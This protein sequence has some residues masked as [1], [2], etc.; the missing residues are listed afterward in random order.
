MDANALA[1]A[2]GT[3]SRLLIHARVDEA[4]SNWTMPALLR[5]MLARVRGVSNTEPAPSILEIRD[6][7]GHRLL[8]LSHA[9]ALIDVVLP[10]GTYHV[11]AQT[12][13]SRRSYTV[14]LQ[15]DAT[16]DLYLQPHPAGRTHSTAT[17]HL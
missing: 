11:T 7:P 16:T 5:R 6:L 4:R 14:V 13:E 10:T 1:G 3:T 17:R 2:Y 9:S 12:G 8:T 15:Q